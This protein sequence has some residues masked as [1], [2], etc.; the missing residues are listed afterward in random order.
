MGFCGSIVVNSS[1]HILIQSIS[2]HRSDSPGFPD[3]LCVFISKR[4]VP[5]SPEA[6]AVPFFSSQPCQMYGSIW[7]LKVYD[8][9][10]PNII[11]DIQDHAS[12]LLWKN[13]P[14]FPIFRAPNWWKAGPV[15]WPW[16][17]LRYE[18]LRCDDYQQGDAAAKKVDLRK[19]NR[20][21]RSKFMTCSILLWL[22]HSSPN[23]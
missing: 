12:L 22:Q 18:T 9:I 19:Q 17:S 7:K 1:L 15:W 14:N 8:M 10:D 23:N 16:R 4:G 2:A 13:I 11:N 21:C 5:V 3:V 20:I 6:S